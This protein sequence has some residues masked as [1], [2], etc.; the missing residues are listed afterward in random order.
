MGLF[1]I[2]AIFYV[3]MRLHFIRAY[4]NRGHA[5]KKTAS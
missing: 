5:C 1:Y 2:P 4:Q 3:C